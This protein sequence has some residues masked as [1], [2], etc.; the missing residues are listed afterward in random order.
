MKQAEATEEL[1]HQVLTLE[2]DM[3]HVLEMMK[4]WLV[5]VQAVQVVAMATLTCMVTQVV[6]P[7]VKKEITAEAEQEVKDSQHA[8]LRQN[9]MQPEHVHQE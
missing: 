3:V 9:Q 6:I 4:I 7:E 2:V 1:V 5:A 8:N